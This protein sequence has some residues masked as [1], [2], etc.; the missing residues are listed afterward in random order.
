MKKYA[1]DEIRN[2][3][4]IGGGRSGKTSLAEAIVFSSKGVSKLGSVDE[5]TTVTDFDPDEIDR[6]NSHHASLASLET[7]RG[8]LNLVDTPGFPN[9]L[10]DTNDQ[11]THDSAGHRG[12]APQNEHRKRLQ[13]N[14]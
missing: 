14:Q 1:A 7:G 5:G 10:T 12:K 11:T 3:A 9:F 13:R 8:K 2:I 4:L 6:K